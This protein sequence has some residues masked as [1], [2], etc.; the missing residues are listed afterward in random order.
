MPPVTVTRHPW[1][2]AFAGGL[3]L[4][5]A[6]FFAVDRVC[7]QGGGGRSLSETAS[8]VSAGARSLSKGVRA[9]AFRSVKAFNQDRI[10]AASAA[11][12]FY[13]LLAIFPALSAFVSLYGLVADVDGARHRINALRGFLPGDAIAVLGDQLARLASADHGALGAAFFVSLLVS[14]VSANAGLKALIAGLNAAFETPENRGS[15][16]L[17][18]ISLGFTT[19][20]L[21]LAVILIATI[22]KSSRLLVPF[23]LPGVA[24]GGAALWAA[25]LAISILVISL[26]YRYA[27]AHREGPRW[28]WITVGGAI[29]AIGW[30]VMTAGFSWFVGAFGH[31]DKVYGS[32]GAIVGFMTWIRLSLMIVLAGAELNGDLERQESAA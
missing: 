30:M 22:A 10:P 32:L 17:N 3:L 7:R 31:F 29:A 11:A 25:L 5:L 27:P 21:G 13:I 9:A 19:G 23:G 20:A 15:V 1:L 8:P 12:T 4:G 18:L 14:V 2:D 6:A 26:L 28:R 24:G 16:R